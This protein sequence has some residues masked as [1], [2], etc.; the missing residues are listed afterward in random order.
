M[1]II[2]ALSRFAADNILNLI[3]LFFREKKN[4]L[5]FHVIQLLGL[6]VDMWIFVINRLD[7]YPQAMFVIDSG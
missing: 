5:I 2:K 4:D 6:I 3:P 1:L 7:E